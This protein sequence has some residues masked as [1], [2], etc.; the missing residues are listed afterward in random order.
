VILAATFIG[1]TSKAIS[2]SVSLSF[3]RLIRVASFIESSFEYNQ[4][5]MDPSWSRSE[6]EE[7]AVAPPIDT[8]PARPE[9]VVLHLHVIGMMC[10]RNC[11]TT[12]TNALLQLPSCLHVETIFVEQRTMAILQ[13]SEATSE[14]LERLQ[15]AA[16]DQIEGIGFDAQVIP[17]LA[18]YL[19]ERAAREKEIA[20][21]ATIETESITAASY[22]SHPAMP[23][24][25]ITTPF[26]HSSEEDDREIV[27]NVRGMSCAVCTGRVERA[28]RHALR[29]VDD[30]ESSRHDHN[31]P[32]NIAVVLANGGTAIC[33]YP[34]P[35]TR[36]E[37]ASLTAT[38]MHAV[39][40]AGYDCSDTRPPEGAATGPTPPLRTSAEQ[41]NHAIQSEYL[42]WRHLLLGAVLFTVPLLYIDHVFQAQQ[43]HVHTLALL[44]WLLLEWILASMVQFGVGMRFYVASYHSIRDGIYGMDFL[45]CMGTTASY[46]YS[47]VM[48]LMFLCHVTLLYEINNDSNSSTS[49]S[50][51]SMDPATTMLFRPI[52]TT[53]ATLLTF[54]TFGKFLESYAKGKTASA[55]HTLMSLQPLLAFR[56]MLPPDSFGNHS[57]SHFRIDDRERPSGCDA[58]LT[59]PVE[60]VA[61]T[62]IR[63]GD[64]L[65][66]WPGARIPTDGVVMAISGSRRDLP[67]GSKLERW[68]TH[69]SISSVHP[70][71]TE[72]EDSSSST[73]RDDDDVLRKA[74]SERAYEAP[75]YI[76]ESALTGEPFPVVKRVGDTVTGSTVNQL[77]VLFLRVTAIG[78][79]TALSK[80]VRLM[81]RA[82][83]NKAP[84]QAYADRIACIFAPTVLVLS[85]ITFTLWIT[86][87]EHVTL[88]ERFFYAFTSAISV[89]VVACPCALGLATPTA[90]MVGTGV[91]A[92][93]GLLIKGGA[94]LENMH[95]IDTIVFDKTFTL[96]TGR[97]ILGTDL[98]MSLLKNYSD[99]DDL[100]QHLP[101]MISKENFAL[102]LAACAELQSEHPLAKAIVN[103]ARSKWGDDVTCSSE[104]VR[105]ENFFLVPG[106][107]VECTLSKP[108]WGT[109]IVRVGS[110]TWTKEKAP[111]VLD[112]DGKRPVMDDLSGDEAA[113]ELRLRGQV[114]VYVSIVQDLSTL[115]V[116]PVDL[117]R[118]VVGVFGI[119]DPLRKESKSTIA[120]LRSMGVDV[121][122]CTGDHDI[123]ARAVARE[124]GIDES[125]VCSGVTPEG[126]AD[127]VSRLHSAYPS[128]ATQWRR[129]RKPRSVAVVG[130]GINDAVAL[131]R[132]DVGIA[133]G[134]G[135]EVAVEAA[136]VVLIRSSLHDVVVA[137]H[138]SKVVFRRILMNFVWAMGYNVCALPF[139][140]GVLYPFT[141]FRLPPELA[142]LMMAFSSVSVV[143][144]S[145]LLRRYQRPAIQEDGSL[146][147]GKG[148]LQSVETTVKSVL[149]RLHRCTYAHYETVSLKP[150]AEIV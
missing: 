133:I 139:A 23:Q 138:L 59:Y 102:W 93:H 148:C 16:I 89:L 130:D 68:S 40:Q 10:Q 70:L 37:R 118:R 113:T 39:Q 78:E 72:A 145:L 77:S 97:A 134:A 147:G 100:L 90:V 30:V 51:A 53:G 80:I 20:C 87:N 21:D 136:D 9:V 8:S 143:A 26:S 107:G 91:G 13:V 141:D 117:K 19:A 106:M 71:M 79:A 1:R 50:S 111:G 46:L 83:R 42:S 12:V 61:V 17:N 125:N 81:E 146:I 67:G 103:A 36:D 45:I 115:P 15:Q 120:A 29:P 73:Y 140:A 41:M 47:V 63:V 31:A 86:L 11:G 144:S 112:S 32:R 14:T 123:T 25:P 76:D 98:S 95:S 119:V 96:T 137:L 43:H 129:V 104:Q 7:N 135:T 88:G 142:G 28:L 27:L 54:V 34:R 150:E 101:S 44:G 114:A 24:Q 4:S 56:V 5:P 64:I 109:W 84:I 22:E 75:A 3:I 18:E 82:Q 85:A 94:V 116:E 58:M 35:L 55:L 69:S 66:V 60:E 6:N 121:W 92:S 122:L 128:S 65:Q 57:S 49:A 132:A 38:A 62:E 126:K 105:V 127:L 74:T 99:D 2:P 124:V 48:V 52:F 110:R 149:T 108:L 33:E 131:A